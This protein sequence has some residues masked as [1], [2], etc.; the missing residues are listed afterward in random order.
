MWLATG[1]IICGLADGKVRALQTKSNKSQS[2]FASDSLVVSL[3]SNSKGTGF[4]SGHVDGN[5]IRF[6]VANDYNEDEAQGRV[7]LY[8]V[9]PCA[10]AWAQGHIFVAGCDKRVS[11]FNNNGK[12]VKNFDYGKDASEHEFTTATCSPSGQVSG[13]VVGE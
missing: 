13:F 6:Y 9:P 3:C 5:V 8:S 12:L 4:L 10:L 1:P 11:V 7:I 2:L